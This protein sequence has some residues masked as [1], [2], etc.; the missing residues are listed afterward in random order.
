[1]K[2]NYTKPMLVMEMFSLMRGT[3]R[4]CMDSIPQGKVNFGDPNQ[5]GWDVGGGTIFFVEG[6]KACT[7]NGEG[8]AGACY[9]NP[10]EG[11]YI[12]RS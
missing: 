1:M 8:I 4:D 5:C 11:S 6:G 2:G 3:S 10:G 7:D 12:F 9:N